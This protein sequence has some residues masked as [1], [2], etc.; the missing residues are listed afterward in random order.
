M[1]K[2][3]CNKC[4]AQLAITGEPVMTTDA[5]CICPHCNGVGRIYNYNSKFVT[6]GDFEIQDCCLCKGTG[7]VNFAWRKVSSEQHYWRSVKDD[8][9]P[10]NL[11]VLVFWDKI[12]GDYVK[13][14]FRF[15]NHEGKE[16]WMRT[17]S[18]NTC[19]P[20]D[21]WMEMPETPKENKDD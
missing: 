12:T 2:I 13:A 5:A 7:I 4:G 1:T 17:D 6:T 21:W 3:F 8:P 16:C 9:P 18:T 20:P 15:F 10:R 19:D 11:E 14:A